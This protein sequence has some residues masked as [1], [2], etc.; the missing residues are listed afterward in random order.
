MLSV[1]CGSWHFLKIHKH[2]KN[3]WSKEGSRGRVSE[4]G[5]VISNIKIHENF[6]IFHS[7]YILIKEEEGNGQGTPSS[8]LPCEALA[9]NLVLQR[10]FTFYKKTCNSILTWILHSLG[11]WT[12]FQIPCVF[13]TSTLEEDVKIFPAFIFF[14]LI[15][16][17]ISF[18][19]PTRYKSILHEHTSHNRR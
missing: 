1:I 7:E 6:I 3:N 9:S 15:K 17:P 2:R 10:H 11:M 19:S 14:V 18:N 5:K 8:L 13:N 4:K 16:L 12:S